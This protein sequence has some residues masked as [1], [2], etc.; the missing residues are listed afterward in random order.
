MSGYV[1][2]NYTITDREGYKAYLESAMPTLGAHGAEVLVADYQ[3]EAREGSPGHV[4]IVLRFESKDEARSWYESVEYQA[5]K[6][7][8]RTTQRASF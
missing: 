6:H 7:H 3:S 2:A 1:V 8:R 5:V 4:T